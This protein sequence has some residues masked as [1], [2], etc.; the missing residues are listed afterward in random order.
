V[1]ILGKF[2]GTAGPALLATNLKNSIVLGVSMIPRA[3]IAMIIIQ[4]GHALGE[5][6]IASEVY[7]GMVLVSA[8]TCVISPLI[9]HKLLKYWPQ[10]QIE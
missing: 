4:Q 9:L 7:A 3:E 2:I 8:V 5:E 10:K 1:A 6:I